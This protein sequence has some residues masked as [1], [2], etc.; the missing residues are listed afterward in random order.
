M[1][2]ITRIWQRVHE[3]RTISILYF[4]SY[5]LL[6]GGGLAALAD[7][8]TSLEGEIGA[9]AM[10]MLATLLVIGGAIGSASALPGVYWLERF[11]VGAIGSSAVIYLWIIVT[12]QFTQSGNRLLQAAFVVAVLAHQCIRWVR[13]RERPYRPE[14]PT[15][16]QA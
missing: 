11:A 3:P 5:L 2:M 1:I 7:P 4:V 14:D 16:A 10:S 12:L 13:I 6:T 15:V 9:T 8:P